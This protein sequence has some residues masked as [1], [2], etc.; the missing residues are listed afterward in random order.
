MDLRKSNVYLEKI[1]QQNICQYANLE[2]II[3][4]YKSLYPELR[5][6]KRIPGTVKFLKGTDL[7]EEFFHSTVKMFLAIYRELRLNARYEIVDGIREISLKTDEMLA[8]CYLDI[9]R[10]MLNINYTKD[11]KSPKAYFKSRVR[12]VIAE[13][14]K[15]KTNKFI[16]SEYELHCEDLE[17]EDGY[18]YL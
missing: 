8:I 7:V 16:E 1:N 15:C 3:F 18:V 14:F 17:D 10:I 2:R 12:M 11:S 6:Y 13:H 5:K 4:E 9:P